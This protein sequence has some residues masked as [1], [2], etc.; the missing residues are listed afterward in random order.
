[1]CVCCTFCSGSSFGI[2]R[3]S[4]TPLNEWSCFTF[5][6]WFLW[7]SDPYLRSVIPGGYRCRCACVFRADAKLVHLSAVDDRCMISES[8]NM[9]PEHLHVWK[10]LWFHLCVHLILS[11]T[12]VNYS[13][14][15]ASAPQTVFAVVK[16]CMISWER[17]ALWTTGSASNDHIIFYEFWPLNIEQQWTAVIS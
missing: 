4:F 7:G 3:S 13:T 2:T 14:R 6:S 1:M 9:K 16:I 12:Y 8:M 10:H 15:L 5:L 17:P 11:K